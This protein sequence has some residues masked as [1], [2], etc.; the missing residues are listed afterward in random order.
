MEVVPFY[1]QCMFGQTA[2]ALPSSALPLFPHREFPMRHSPQCSPTL[3]GR[4]CKGRTSDHVRPQA[5]LHV[6]FG[7]WQV[8]PGSP[9]RQRDGREE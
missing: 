5:V 3:S 6:C 9:V 8:L 4:L 7:P 2:L 1:R